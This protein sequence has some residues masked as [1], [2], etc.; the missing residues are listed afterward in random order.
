[1]NTL[2]LTLALSSPSA[3][4][5][6]VVIN[7]TTGPTHRQT[8]ISVVSRVSSTS[9]FVSSDYHSHTCRNGHTWSHSSS[10]P[11]A[12]HNCPICGTFQNIVDPGSMGRG[13]VGV[14]QSSTYSLGGGCANGNC[15]IP[16]QS[17]SRSGW[18]PGKLLGR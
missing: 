12:S 14:Q 15:S 17:N 11:N 3:E 18:Y 1:M 8:D 2:I 6:Y 10:D 9:K 7:K 13:N 16:Q 5:E 4:P